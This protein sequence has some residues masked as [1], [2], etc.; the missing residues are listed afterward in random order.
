MLTENWKSLTADQKYAERMRVW[1]EPGLEFANPEAAKTHAFK[2]QTIRDA[3]ELRKPERVPICPF[4]G[5]YPARYAGLTMK[6]AM[7]DYG[8][9]AEAMR[10][11]H[12]DFDVDAYLSCGVFTPGKVLDLVDYKLYE[13][14]GHG[15]GDDQGFQTVEGEYMLADEYDALIQ[16]PTGYWIR[17]YLP[18]AF[19]AMQAWS[20][21]PRFPNI[22]EIPSVGPA[23]APFGLPEVQE[24]LKRLM[25]AGKAALEWRQAVGAIDTEIMATYGLPSF[26]GGFSKAPFDIIGDTLRGTKPMMFD[27]FRRPAK[28]LEAVE[29]IVPWAIEMGVRTSTLSRSPMVFMPLHKGVDSFMSPKDFDKFYWPTL[30][31]VILGLIEEGCVP[32]L[33]VEGF[34]NTRLDT[35]AQAGI[36]E[37][38]TMW[39]FE[40]TDMRQAKAKVGGW[41]CIGG[42]VSGSLM[43]AAT[44][45]DVEAYVADL[46]GATAHNGGFILGTGIS[47][48]EA[49]AENFQAMIT[50]GRAFKG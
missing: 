4:V 46:L 34:Y 25:E 3:I 27:L 23:F 6:E 20:M 29:S 47:L 9:V 26:R 1:M 45:Q 42:N 21:L 12:A 32:M 13:W 50:A 11:F 17:Q 49:R 33:F 19:G 37:A 14:P 41:G 18:R 28:V 5:T 15:V 39:I 40:G 48:S 16:D 2:A 31:A 8:R 35:I 44:P 36:P 43:N 38:R 10:K 7:Y 30:K 24:S 22:V